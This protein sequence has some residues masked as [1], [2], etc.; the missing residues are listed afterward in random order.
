MQVLRFS[1]LGT[2]GVIFRR[3]ERSQNGFTDFGLSA[4]DTLFADWLRRLINLKKGVS[5]YG[6][7]NTKTTDTFKFS[8]LVM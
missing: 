5:C 3:S 4:L 8:F 7:K 1:T 6:P 2:M